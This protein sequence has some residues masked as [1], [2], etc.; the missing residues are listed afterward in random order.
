M[1]PERS[2]VHLRADKCGMNTGKEAGAQMRLLKR[3]TR[4][5]FCQQS[6]TQVSCALLGSE[7]AS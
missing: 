2:G 3:G 4:V 7:D 1:V 6:L 5:L